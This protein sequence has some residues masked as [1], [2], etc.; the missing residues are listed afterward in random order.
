MIDDEPGIQQ[1]NSFKYFQMQRHELQNQ[2]KQTTNDIYRMTP[3]KELFV[4][5]VNQTE[6]KVPDENSVD[7]ISD[8][9]NPY[10]QAKGDLDGP[11]QTQ[12]I[13]LKPQYVQYA[14]KKNLTFGFK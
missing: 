6:V 11:K 12:V 10:A 3:I 4:G 5:A 9:E 1:L 14:N 13:D 7:E 2:M 8:E